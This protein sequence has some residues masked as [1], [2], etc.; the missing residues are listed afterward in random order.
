MPLTRENDTVL[1]D[2]YTNTLEKKVQ[3]KD[4][5]AFLSRHA[6]TGDIPEELP[7][8]SDH[9]GGKQISDNE[10]PSVS[11]VI[12]CTALLHKFKCRQSNKLLILNSVIIL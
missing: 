4:S 6:D 5:G 12:L 1:Q 10:F 7:P 3:G 9:G 11:M 8:N 2:C